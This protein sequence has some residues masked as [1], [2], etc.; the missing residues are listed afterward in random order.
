MNKTMN[1]MFTRIQVIV[2]PLV[3]FNSVTAAESAGDRAAAV[4]RTPGL[5]AFW[6]FV[7]REPD[8]Q[9]RFTAHVPEG[10]KTDYP[11]D[12]A[13]YVKDYW[14]AGR[15]ATYDDFPLLGRGPFG[16]AIRIAKE[17]D[18][19]FRPFLFVPRA[20]LHDTPLDIKGAGKSVT[21]VVWAIRES[22][23]HA[24]AGIWHE[25]TD[26]KQKETSGIAK[27]ERGQRQYALFAGLNKEGSACG[28]VSENG[29]SSFL[30]K[31]ALHKCNSLGLSP[32]MPADAPVETL[33][34]AW[35]CFAMTFDHEKDEL[36]GWLNGVAGDRWLENPQKDGLL[37][38]AANAWLQGRLRR[39]P[40]LQPGEDPTFPPEQFYNPPEEKPV[41]V[42]VV[43]ETADERVELR[44]YGY[45]KVKVTLR[46]GRE[47]ARDLVA[48]RLNPWWYPHDLYAPK[49]DGSGG[50]FTIGRVIHSSRGVGFTG[51]IGGVAVFDRALRTEELAALAVL[52]IPPQPE[53]LSVSGIYPHLTVFNSDPKREKP[54]MEC[55]LG[56]AVPWAGKLWSTTYT[57]HA[58]GRGNDKLF[59]VRPD[60][61][62]EIRPE[63]VGGTSACR[64]I[65]RESRQLF[66]A[67]YAI[68]DAG[69]VRVI[70][71]EQ[72]P[73]RLT[74]LARH[75]T[76][77]ENKVLYL[78][79]EGAVYEVDVHSLAVTEL[80][81]KPLPG[82]HYKGAW[83]AQGRF[84]VA[85]NGE[86]PAPSPF[87]KVDYA[88]AA[89]KFETEK[90]TWQYL[91]T[92][93]QPLAAPRTEGQTLWKGLSEDMGNLG[94]WDGQTWRVLS[95]RQHLDISG[96]GG[97]AGA[98]SDD[99]PVWALGWDLRSAFIKVREKS[100][101]W[102]IYR[103]PK[104]SYTADGL[105]GSNTEWPRICDV[106]EGPRLL[107]LHNG[108]YDLPVG[109]RDGH[110]A[111]L[112]HLAST[113]VTVTDMTAWNGRLVFSQ[114]AT[115]VH[116]IPALVPGQPH[117]NLQFLQRSDLPSWGPAE[118]RG[119]VWVEDAVMANT[120]SD[121]ILVGG[122]ERRCVH[123]V[124]LSDVAVTFTFETDSDGSGRWKELI[125]RT[126]PT[127]GYS[128]FL[129]PSGLKAEWLRVRSSADCIATV[130]LHVAS[131]RQAVAGEARIF[132][133]L[134]KSAEGAVSIGG[135]VR[136]GFPTANLQFLTRDGRYFEV[137]EA[138]AF[139]AA[140]ATNEIAK[141]QATH[142]LTNAFSEDAASLIVTRYDGQR[143]R[144]PKGEAE[145]SAAAASR[146]V[147]EC[148]QERYLANYH[149]T[150]YE[151]PRGAKNLPDYQRMKPV[152]TH[153]RAIA[154]FCV[155]RGLLVL[156]G[157]KADAAS[158]GHV[159]G[160]ADTKLWF[161]AIDDLWKLGKP[162]GRGGPWKE[163]S[164]KARESSDPY[165]MAGYD[166]KTLTLS[167]D[168]RHPV[169][170][171]VEV[172]FYA[173][174]RW[175]EYQRLTVAPGQP[176]AYD[177]PVGYAT[178]WLRVQANA[179]CHATAQLVYR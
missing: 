151:V 73:G 74:A 101:S 90:L 95:R 23:N 114:Q 49:N 112:R 19:D 161:G 137:D 169:E 25:G 116:G 10:A 136:A 105:H 27:V 29:A 129:L 120:P 110:S 72:L 52:R 139:H 111:G 5:V 67:S 33:D 45:T 21:V 93:Y 123:L 8:G 84:F 76:D 31:Y 177:F 11:L 117:S 81:K 50:P 173:D 133:G 30:N 34:T 99:E 108:L 174:G 141:L 35:Q 109:F 16:Q 162:R 85:A 103:L 138:L 157:V 98:M 22:G 32:A 115:S 1:L 148:I 156:S 6:D 164:V 18:P 87:W 2:L 130:F 154:D 59:A 92:P 171:T 66:I 60:M 71:R 176:L 113:L 24:L 91:Q 125:T 121:A 47:A 96:P 94:E 4:K 149:G 145:L 163:T 82:W 178:H 86:E 46:G 57:S 165:L 144:L 107:F 17:K 9:R 15:E 175:H 127:K 26:L 55:G 80:F 170:F 160:N 142:A 132:Q 155:W 172:D 126:L 64:M 28:H 48:L 106:G 143:F 79:Q 159:F 131:P 3:A 83:T 43:S 146:S 53:P 44:E 20:R 69:K 150:I 56:A 37:S 97:L 88:S 134:V 135:I 166:Q 12:A 167:H 102:T 128:P 158:D 119:G 68:D 147:R 38:F 63:S 77:A 70:P 65:H 89:T 62:L 124:N 14:S 40:G 42:Q 13:N 122:Y 58:L 36:T 140:E 78:T 179:D 118:A 168:S 104:A 75:L 7:K 54:E 100:G 61:T 153:N 41:A 39:E 152:A 51:W